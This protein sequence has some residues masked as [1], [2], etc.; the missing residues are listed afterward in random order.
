MTTVSIPKSVGE[1]QARLTD[2]ERLLT[3][4]EWERA[5]IVAAFVRLDRGNGG[6]KEV[7]TSTHFVSARE[8][9]RRGVIGLKSDR[10]VSFYVKAW[11]GA[12]DGNYPEPG[13][14]VTLPTID[15]PSQPVNAGSRPTPTNI[16]KQLAEDPKLAQAAATALTRS[17]PRIVADAI[18]EAPHAGEAIFGDVKLRREGIDTSPAAHKAAGAAAHRMVEPILRAIVAGNTIL[19]LSALNEATEYLREIID[20]GAMNDEFMAE[21]EAATERYMLVLAEARMRVS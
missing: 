12:N 5:A 13:S 16:G 9:A 15:F 11:L 3:A 14:T 19:F 17:Q 4:K 18:M 1:A 20:G 21:V 2:V 7:R 10:T 6:R 8:F